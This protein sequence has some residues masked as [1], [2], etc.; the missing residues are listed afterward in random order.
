MKDLLDAE[1]KPKRDANGRLIPG[2]VTYTSHEQWAA[3]IEEN[4]W[5]KVDKNGPT[6]AHKPELGPCWVWT[7]CQNPRG[8]G[9]F[10]YFG[11]RTHAH[12]VV[13]FLTRDVEIPKHLYVCHR[14][15]TPSCVNPD[16]LFLGTAK[17]NAQDAKAK[18]RL[19]AGDNHYSRTN[20]EKLARGDRSYLRMHPEK[21]IRGDNHVLTK[22]PDAEVPKIH[23]RYRAGDTM[24][25]I[26]AD[27]SCDPSN[28]ALIVKGKSRKHLFPN[29]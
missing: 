16:H 2:F 11:K 5:K 25:A 1:N 28:I 3:K 18:G 13:W 22:I 19:P 27:Y 7:A 29:P 24:T 20:P 15:D 9:E 21:V 23:E 26:A 10:Q 8:Y 14:C 12:R 17:E 6:P 4:F